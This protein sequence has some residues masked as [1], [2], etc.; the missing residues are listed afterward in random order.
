MDVILTNL[1]EY[2]MGIAVATPIRLMLPN[3]LSTRGKS[4]WDKGGV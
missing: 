3:S 1:L 4:R 2:S